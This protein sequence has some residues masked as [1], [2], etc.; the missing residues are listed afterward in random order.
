MS[1]CKVDV[2][3]NKNMMIQ[4]EFFKFGHKGRQSIWGII[5]NAFLKS[6]NTTPTSVVLS[7]SC[8]H[9]CV[10]CKSADTV[11]FL[12]LEPPLAVCKWSVDC[13]VFTNEGIDMTFKN[14]V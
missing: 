12:L 5:T 7:R 8:N 6:K 11:D 13:D 14:F 9:S 3:P 10:T 1:D 4:L 2:D